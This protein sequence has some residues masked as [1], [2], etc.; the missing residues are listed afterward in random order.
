MV[1]LAAGD[2]KLKSIVIDT[3][4]TCDYLLVGK[5]VHVIFKEMEVSISTQPD[6]PISL[7]NEITGKITRL[8]IGEILSKVTLETEVGTVVSVISTNSAERLGL[9]EEQQVYAMI[10]TNEIMLSAE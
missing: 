7:Q 9:K 10:K 8:E 3:A 2:V 4:S 1:S 6:L 5:E